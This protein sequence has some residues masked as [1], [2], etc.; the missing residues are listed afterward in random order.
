MKT[1]NFMLL[2]EVIFLPTLYCLHENFFSP[3][4][5]GWAKNVRLNKRKSKTFFTGYSWEREFQCNPLLL[6]MWN[7]KKKISLP[8]WKLHENVLLYC[9][10]SSFLLFSGDVPF[11]YSLTHFLLNTVTYY[12]NILIPSK[13][14]KANTCTGR[15]SLFY[16]YSWS[17][18]DKATESVRKSWQLPCKGF[19]YNRTEH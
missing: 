17:S 8:S 9:F 13:S 19:F 2:H 15:L 3:V 7:N 14:F 6:S 16:H 5:A 10:K 18:L 4:S 11:C 12:K 1:V